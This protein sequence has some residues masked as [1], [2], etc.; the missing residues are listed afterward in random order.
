MQRAMDDLLSSGLDCL[1][2]QFAAAGLEVAELRSAQPSGSGTYVSVGVGGHYTDIVLSDEFV[3]DLPKT[4]K[5]N[6]ALAAYARGI[7]SRAVCGSPESFYSRSGKT[8]RIEIQWPVEFAVFDSTASGFLRVEVTNDIEGDLAFCAVRLSIRPTF[9]A[10]GSRWTN[11]DTARFVVNAVRTAIDER[12][13]S[14][15]KVGTCPKHYK[16]IRPVADRTIEHVSKEDVQRFLAGK[17]YALGFQVPNA[18]CDVWIADPWDAEYLGV[19]TKDFSQSAHILKAKHLLDFPRGGDFGRPS[20]KLLA[21]WPEVLNG[22]SSRGPTKD[23]TLTCLPNKSSLQSEVDA[24]IQ[25][26]SMVSLLLIDLDNFKTVNDTKGHL[27]GDRCLEALVKVIAKVIGRRGTLYRWGGDE[28]AV[29]LPDFSGPEALTS[30][31]RIRST[32]EQAD[33]GDGVPV[34]TS[35]G[36]AATD[37][38]VA[39]SAE[40]LLHAADM[41]M[42]ASKRGGKNQVTLQNEGGLAKGA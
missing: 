22:A 8:V 30:A 32:V 20:D 12:E 37:Q 16:W 28:F 41:A 29:S 13:V 23:M 39:T 26:Q 31:E 18:P 19:S 3:S 34:T 7:A 25:S 21:D 35:I 1:R 33:C 38:G 4:Q 40:S 15:A 10:D 11:F 42:Y 27:A 9:T 14:F 24:L 5:Y 6:D 17:V 36:V 2:R